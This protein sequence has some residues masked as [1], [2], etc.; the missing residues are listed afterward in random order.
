M[1]SL[2]SEAFRGVLVHFI[3]IPLMVC[4]DCPRNNNVLA[5][6]LTVFLACIFKN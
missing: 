3:Q 6:L 5:V 4:F 1:F 2:C